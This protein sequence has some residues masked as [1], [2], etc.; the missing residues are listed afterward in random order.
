[1]E[2]MPTGGEAPDNQQEREMSF[3]DQVALALELHRT[4]MERN[5]FIM[6]QGGFDTFAEAG[7]YAPGMREAYDQ[8]AEADA[9]AEKELNEKI[10]DKQELVGKLKDA[11]HTEAART[12]ALRFE[13]ASPEDMPKGSA[14][15]RFFKGR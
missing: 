4:T 2:Q 14:I 11:G 3:E 8:L 1:M 9:R 7:Q 6:R 5:D 15:R 12:V 10:K 13:I